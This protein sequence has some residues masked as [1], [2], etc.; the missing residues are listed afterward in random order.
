LATLAFLARFGTTASAAWKIGTGIAAA[1]RV[2]FGESSIAATASVESR[3]S[4]TFDLLFDFFAARLRG[5]FGSI[6]IF[7]NPLAHTF[8]KSFLYLHRDI[9]SRGPPS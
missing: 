2:R 8:D 4:S 7:S 9:H 5:D 1:L 3:L 6:A